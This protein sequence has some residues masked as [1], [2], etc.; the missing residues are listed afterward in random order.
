MTRSTAPGVGEQLQGAADED[1]HQRQ[2]VAQHGLVERKVVT[3]GEAADAELLVAEDGGFRQAL[4]VAGGEQGPLAGGA[5]PGDVAEEEAHV[6][7][8]ARREIGIGLA[9]VEVAE[10]EVHE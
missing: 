4:G 1:P 10:R 5:G 2:A 3:V 7:L 8:Q 9:T 6:A